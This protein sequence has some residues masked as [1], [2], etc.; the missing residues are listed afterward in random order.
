MRVC[1]RI[2]RFL[3]QAFFFLHKYIAVSTQPSYLL[4]EQ[5]RQSDCTSEVL[6]LAG[7]V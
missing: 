2:L 3:L 7:V 1:F 6:D 5:M 4:T